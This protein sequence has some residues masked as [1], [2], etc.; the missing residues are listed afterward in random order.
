M[1]DN[2]FIL[3]SLHNHLHNLVEKRKEDILFSATNKFLSGNMSEREALIVIASLAE[4]IRL[5]G[6]LETEIAIVK[7]KEKKVLDK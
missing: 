3:S 4:L 7:R 6:E 1:S 2:L 5:L